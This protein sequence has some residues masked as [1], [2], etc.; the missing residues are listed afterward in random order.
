MRFTSD[1][2][3]NH[4][5]TSFHCVCVGGRCLSALPVIQLLFLNVDELDYISTQPRNVEFSTML[6]QYAALSRENSC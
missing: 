4:I 5:S 3:R 6:I 1:C 2:R